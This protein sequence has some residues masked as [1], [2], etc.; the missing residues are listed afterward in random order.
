MPFWRRWCDDSLTL[1][2][3]PYLKARKNT[4]NSSGTHKHAL[5]ASKCSTI[6]IYMFIRLGAQKTAA[7]A[8]NIYAIYI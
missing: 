8:R 2:R 1:K 7:L 6:Y 3:I 5:R 4:S